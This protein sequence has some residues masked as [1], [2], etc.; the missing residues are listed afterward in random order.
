MSLTD[1]VNPYFEYQGPK[2]IR[3]S[4]VIKLRTINR[5]QEIKIFPHAKGAISISLSTEL[6]LSLHLTISY[7]SHGPNLVGGANTIFKANSRRAKETKAQTPCSPSESDE[8]LIPSKDQ[9]LALCAPTI[10]S[11]FKMLFSEEDAPLLKKW[12]IKRL[13]NT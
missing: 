13:E 1:T 11:I 8:N 9:E 3:S 7:F 2:F 5:N 4:F 10:K 12:I 6:N